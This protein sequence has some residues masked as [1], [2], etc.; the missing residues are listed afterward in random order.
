MNYTFQGT[1]ACL[2]TSLLE[3]GLLVSNEQ[4][5]DGSG[6]HFCI[7]RQGNDFGTGHVSEEDINKL[8]RGEEWADIASLLHFLSFIGQ[9]DDI[10]EYIA[11]TSFVHKLSDLG[12][13]YGFESVIGVD[14]YPLTEAEATEKYLQ[15]A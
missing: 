3:Y 7:Y 8:L 14:Y 4:H 11:D 9:G 13:Y 15:T 2:E 12:N 5:E 1:D 10:E 6:T